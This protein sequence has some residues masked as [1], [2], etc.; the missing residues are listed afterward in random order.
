[1]TVAVQTQAG[2]P[3]LVKHGAD[4]PRPR[5]GQL[6]D[7]SLQLTNTRPVGLDGQQDG[8]RDREGKRSEV[9]VTRRWQVNNYVLV[10]FVKFVIVVAE[11]ASYLRTLFSIDGTAGREDAQTRN[12]GIVNHIEI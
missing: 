2:R 8:I 5:S 4:K 10:A 3:W 6:T 1:M 9:W 12:G 11:Q 7:C